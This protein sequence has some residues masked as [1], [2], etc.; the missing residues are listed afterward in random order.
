M[1]IIF[2][3]LLLI[4][5]ITGGFKVRSELGY[6]QTYG[7]PSSEGKEL[8]YPARWLLEQYYELPEANRPYG[9]MKRIVRALD[10]KHGVDTMNSHFAGYKY[11]SGRQR[12]DWSN[13][14]TGSNCYEHNN[15]N[16]RCKGKDYLEL[17][18]A[19]NDISE[20]LGEQE[21]ALALA[22]VQDGIGEAKSLMEKFREE[23][24]LINKVTK[25]L[26]P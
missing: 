16:P 21:Y 9:D 12:P 14:W 25:E 10:V 22:G 3:V 7:L 6:R 26:T 2:A 17:R 23:K 4:A 5:V 1:M 8:S 13:G 24:E 19:M 18:N 20:A 11:V 15:T